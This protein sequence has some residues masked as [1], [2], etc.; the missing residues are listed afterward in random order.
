[1]YLCVSLAKNWKTAFEVAQS[2]RN[3]A[4]VVL[5]KSTYFTTDLL[6]LNLYLGH[7]FAHLFILGNLCTWN[8]TEHVDYVIIGLSSCKTKFLLWT[9]VLSAYL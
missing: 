3:F 7:A 4:L 9:K 8:Q 1:M 2:L 5:Q 6:D